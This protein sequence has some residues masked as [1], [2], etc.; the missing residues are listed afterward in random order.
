MNE[1]TLHRGRHPHLTVVDAYFD[2]QH[3]TE[4]VVSR[5]PTGLADSDNQA[6]G[7]L[8][9]T[10]TGST[11]YSLSAGGPISHP[12]TD[13]F[14]LTPIAPRSLSFRTVVLPGRGTVQLKVSLSHPAK[15]YDEAYDRYPILQ[16]H[17][18][19]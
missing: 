10:P 19:N 12:E 18:R 2:N 14:L 4:A 5:F 6:D 17:L 9:S 13:A 11:A 16:E 8:L 1:V 3:L 15:T 7:L